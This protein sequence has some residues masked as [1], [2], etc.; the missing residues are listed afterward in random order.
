MHRVLL[1]TS[2]SSS[3][4]PVMI[5][6]LASYRLG[7]SARPSRAR[8]RAWRIIFRRDSVRKCTSFP[9]DMPIGT[10]KRANSSHKVRNSFVARVLAVTA[11]S[12]I[13]VLILRDSSFSNVCGLVLKPP[14]PRTR[15][16]HSSRLGS[17]AVPNALLITGHRAYICFWRLCDYTCSCDSGF[18]ERR[19]TST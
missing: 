19:N 1:E 2:R 11:S 6:S 5:S 16:N 10:V 18:S 17:N 12:F 7:G 4:R 14:S 15:R 13:R 3:I 8:Q 9:D